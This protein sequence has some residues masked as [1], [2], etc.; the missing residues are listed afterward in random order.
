MTLSVLAFLVNLVLL[1]LL[2]VRPVLLPTVLCFIGAGAL[3]STLAT[4]LEQWT[5]ET[6][7]GPWWVWL[8]IWCA[9]GALAVRVH[10]PGRSWKH[11]ALTVLG[12]AS[13]VAAGTAWVIRDEAAEQL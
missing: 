7:I 10:Q 6:T 9:V 12:I 8:V 4:V 2:G 1:R 11:P 13:L 5:D 3:V